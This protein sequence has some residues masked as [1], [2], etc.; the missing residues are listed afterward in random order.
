VKFELPQQQDNTGNLPL[1]VAAGNNQPYMC[2]K[3]LTA[4]KWSIKPLSVKNN[5]GQT[6][7]H[8]ATVAKPQRVGPER[9]FVEKHEKHKSHDHKASK[10]KE[11]EKEEEDDDYEHDFGLPILQLMW[12]ITLNDVPGSGFFETDDDGKT[13]L[14]LAAENGKSTRY[15]E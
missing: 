15:V 3:F 9:H 13:C 14:H 6:A 2:E 11:K 10:E 4:F 7:V 5:Q 1:H 8:V 12:K